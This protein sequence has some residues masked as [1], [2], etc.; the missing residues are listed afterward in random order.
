M[1]ERL[2]TGAPDLDDHLDG[3]IVPGS[4]VTLRANPASQAELF[5]YRAAAPRDALYLT[6]ARSVESV[7]DTL[8]SVPFRTGEVEIRAVDT[9]HSIQTITDELS[10]VPDSKTVIIDKVDV[11]ERE[12]RVRYR[13]FLNDLSELLGQI[14]GV[15]YLHATT[16]SVRPECRDSTEYLSDVILDVELQI[17]DDVIARLAVPKYRRGAALRQTFDY[18][19]TDDITLDKT[20]GIT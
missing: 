4:L 10:Q 20:R 8:D 2:S 7:R 14:E 13:S 11:L 12:A 6:T 16:G 19:L 9:D 15:A 3:G 1:A 5:L 17:T 18:E